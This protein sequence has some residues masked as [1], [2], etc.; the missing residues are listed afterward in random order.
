[1]LIGLLY[2]LFHMSYL[3]SAAD[4][5]KTKTII[6]GIVCIIIALLLCIIIARSVSAPL[7]RLVISMKK[8]KEGDLTSQIQ[9]NENDEISEVC[10]NYNYM[11]SN[12]NTL[13]SEVRSTS[14]SVHEQANNIALASETAHTASE[15]VAVTVEQIAKG[16]T[17]QATEINDSVSHMDKLS[18]GITYVGDDVSRVIAIANKI[19][20]LNEE[21]D[22]I[23]N[24][25]DIC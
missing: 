17:E 19:S 15:Q 10:H 22:K 24:T 11:L 3:N 1:M 14:Q 9:D 12:I 8:A 20:N 5:L 6:M 23:C 2:Q 16:A 4:S 25:F 18:E 7:N 13:V 21:A